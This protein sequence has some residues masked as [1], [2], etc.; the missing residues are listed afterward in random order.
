MSQRAPRLTQGCPAAVVV[1]SGLIEF[2]DVSV[3]E[4]HL[5]RT[6]A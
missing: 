4:Q 2:R 1:E 5:L 6:P 3:N